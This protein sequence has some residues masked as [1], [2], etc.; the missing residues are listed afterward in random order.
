MYPSILNLIQG[1]RLFHCLSFMKS[2]W[3]RVPELHF[4]L[5]ESMVYI[6]RSL[7][8]RFHM[9]CVS[10]SQLLKTVTECLVYFIF[11]SHFLCPVWFS[12]GENRHLV[13]F[14]KCL[15]LLASY[16]S[17]WPHTSVWLKVCV[18][19]TAESCLNPLLLWIRCFGLLWSSWV[20][21]CPCLTHSDL[22]MA[23]GSG[24]AVLRSPFFRALAPRASDLP[25]PRA[26]CSGVVL[27]LS[28]LKFWFG[29]TVSWSLFS[30]FLVP[31]LILL[32]DSLF[33]KKICMR[34]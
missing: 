34:G 9:G 2:S 19:L 14:Y 16:T 26:L 11:R 24:H 21:R 25:H 31:S 13:L 5:Y 27:W 28:C 4:L 17:V 15:Q 8:G 6:F 1:T 18:I 33:P 32:E 10:C 12:F 3:T 7:K 20:P 23:P 30:L 29:P 22:D